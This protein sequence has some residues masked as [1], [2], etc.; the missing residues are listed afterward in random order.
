MKGPAAPFRFL[1]MAIGGWTASRMLFLL[2]GD[3]DVPSR[4]AE[5]VAVLTAAP[6]TPEP[7]RAAALRPARP[8]DAHRAGRVTVAPDAPEERG[9]TGEMWRLA[10]LELSPVPPPSPPMP[11]PDRIAAS[12][13]QSR[14]SGSAWLYARP[15]GGRSGFAA[16][17]QLGG[18][19]AGARIAWRLTGRDEG[20]L[21]MAARISTPLADARGAEAAVG[22]DWRPLAKVP[23]R[24]SVE[25]RIAL[26]QEGRDAW[27]AYAAGGFWRGNLPAGLE[28]DGYGQ[29]GV[30]GARSRDLF[31]DGAVRAGRA[32]RLAGDKRLVL[33]AGVWG[34]AQPGLGRLDIGP[35][36]A[37][38]AAFTLAADF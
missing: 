18:S 11:R 1:I 15:D 37:L 7:A 10:E 4:A 38:S 28:V 31:A 20:S 30:V 9:E 26:G 21:A 19:Q 22:L 2:P 27:S 34:A 33:G 5:S 8:S 16:G 32:I 14:W 36:A 6:S 12:P 3:G 25:R 17:G 13:R 23:F 29:A 35:R 24:L